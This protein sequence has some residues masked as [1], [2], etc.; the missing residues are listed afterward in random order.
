[1][2]NS[3]F[4]FKQFRIEQGNCGMKVTTEACLFG[5]LMAQSLPSNCKNILDIGTGTGLLA[6]M[7]AQKCKA[8]IHALEIDAAAFNQAKH[9]FNYAPWRERLTVNHIDLKNFES[10]I[11]FDLIICN[12][13]FFK[14]NQLGK[15]KSKNTA[16]HND[17][18]SFEALAN[19]IAQLINKEKGQAAVLYPPY[20]M[21]LFENEMANLGFHPQSTF[22]ILNQKGL[23]IFRQVKVFAHLTSQANFTKEIMIKNSD[24]TY[25][26][27]F[28]DLLKDYYLHL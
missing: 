16:L 9:N 18:L 22:T 14:K 4:Q 24:S 7:L 1:M 26:T 28:I 19:G 8:Q 6:L 5:A 23:P 20:E 27:T 13:P 10:H 12:P 3:Y 15:N 25:S 11:T 17:S 21:A 2:A